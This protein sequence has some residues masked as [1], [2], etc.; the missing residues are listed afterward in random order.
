MLRE[1]HRKQRNFINLGS[2]HRLS[3][4]SSEQLPSKQAVGEG[5]LLCGIGVERGLNSFDF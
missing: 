2:G 5:G 3:R 4:E 1:E